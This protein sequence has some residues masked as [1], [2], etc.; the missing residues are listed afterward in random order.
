M[1]CIAYAIRFIIP[2]NM[3]LPFLMA[4][5]NLILYGLNDKL[6]TCI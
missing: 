4:D 3:N 1:Y 6:V 5:Y 2:C